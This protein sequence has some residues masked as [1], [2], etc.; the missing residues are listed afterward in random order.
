R[1]V[2]PY[3]EKGG[4]VNGSSGL[5]D[6]RS[7]AVC[8]P[9][10]LIRCYCGRSPAASSADLPPFATWEFALEGPNLAPDGSPL[11]P[12]HDRVPERAL[13]PSDRSGFG[14]PAA[15]PQPPVRERIADLHRLLG[16]LDRRDAVQP[17]DAHG[18]RLFGGFLERSHLLPRRAF[19]P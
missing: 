16:A 3:A 14:P 5:L 15:A 7:C 1:K 9:F 4:Q 2:A 10:A 8:A 11:R 13:P 6:P 18:R 19:A 12:A 17:C